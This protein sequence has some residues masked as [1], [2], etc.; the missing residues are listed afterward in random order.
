MEVDGA[1][2]AVEVPV[3]GRSAAEMR[4]ESEEA[5]QLRDVRN[6]RPDTVNSGH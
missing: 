3:R 6:S 4:A 5:Q 1:I 2:E